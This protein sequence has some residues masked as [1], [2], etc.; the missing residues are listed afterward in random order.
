MKT[1]HYSIFVASLII[2][3]MI[4]PVWASVN[5]EIFLPIDGHPIT[6]RFE[7]TK[8][9]NIDYPNGGKLKDLLQG[10]NIT[11]SFTENS[12]NNPTVKS[13]MQQIN[14]EFS[15]QESS[16]SFSNLTISYNVHILG[17]NNV[18]SIDYDITLTPTVE[19]YTLSKGEFDKPTIFDA[20]WITFDMKSPIVI[21]TKQYGN[22]EINYPIDVIKTLP[23]V[24]YILQGTDAENALNQNLVDTAIQLPFDRWDSL[25]DP[26]YT[27]SDTAGVS[28]QGKKVTTTSFSAVFGDRTVSGAPIRNSDMD[29]TVDSKY[30]LSIPTK[31]HGGIVSVEGHANA[32]S[33]QGE[34][35][36]STSIAHTGYT[37]C[38]GCIAPEQALFNSI[39][40]ITI[41]VSA[42]IGFWIFYFRRFRE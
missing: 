10:K 7:F 42:V 4:T 41:G 27:V 5:Y 23:D 18:T 16:A 30:H 22:L 39:L 20:S 33:I 31:P 13:L 12:N 14:N 28:Y 36:F 34:P 11:I 38:V 19:G 21:N 35:A 32:Y 2:L 37:G 29:F 6:P 3:G 24:Y 25:F 40:I 8:T 9:V 26:A 15:K 1:L 17:K